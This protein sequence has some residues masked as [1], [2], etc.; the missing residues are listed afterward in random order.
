MNRSHHAG[1]LFVLIGVILV[2]ASVRA[3]AAPPMPTMGDLQQ[4]YDAGQFHTCLQQ[5]ARVLPGSDRP[6][7]G[8][9]RLQLMLLRGECLMR[10]GARAEAYRAFTAAQ[11]SPEAK[12]ALTARANVVLIEASDQFR[13][14]PPGGG[15]QTIDIQDPA[16]R[17]KAMGALFDAQLGKYRPQIDKAAQAPSLGPIIDVLPKLK[18]L[19]ALEMTAT[20]N[21]RELRPSL[22]AIGQ[23]ARDLIGGALQQVEAQVAQVQQRA[24]QPVMTPV[25]G[26]SQWWVTA[27]RQGL[28]SNDRAQLEDAIN[29]ADSIH[30]ATQQGLVT[31]EALGGKV[32]LWTALVDRARDVGN[33]ARDVLNAE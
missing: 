7:S 6:N 13:Y 32:D 23:R 16:N 8:F 22:M 20:G 31:S 17:R 28:D 1:R 15:G 10:L 18:D 4:M 14:R 25:T 27:G 19:A 5:I 12:T 24:S 3:S 26:G 9:D 11:A 33:H 21:D 2:C 30:N 29:S